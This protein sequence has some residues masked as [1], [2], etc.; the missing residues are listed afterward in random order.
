MVAAPRLP[1]IQLRTLFLLT[2]SGRIERENDPDRSPGPRMWLRGCADGNV[3]AVRSDIDDDVADALIALAATEPPFTDPN[4]RPKYL[5]RY[6][7]LL[8]RDAASPRT[9]PGLTYELPHRVKHESGV[10]LIDN[11]N[12]EGRHLH[13]HLSAHA[14]P[15]GL[16]ELGFR[17]VADLWR[18]WCAAVIDGEI[19]SLAFA[20]RISDAGAE[21]GVSTVRAFRGRGY[22]AAAVAGWSKLP[23]LQSRELFYSTDLENVSSQ[24]LAAR[25]RL[26]LV[27]ASMRLL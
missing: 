22:G 27:G 4:D 20:A 24:R 21:L 17:N 10:A 1:A 14:L 13:D 3:A 25:L 16:A 19:V 23:M 7:G 12:A 18:P 9:R 26:R 2:T 5:D 6:I 15:Q 8:S 11:E